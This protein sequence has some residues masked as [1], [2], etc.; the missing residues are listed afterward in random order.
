MTL[1][2][3]RMN[4]VEEQRCFLLHRLAEVV[5]EIGEGLQI[6]RTALNVAEEEPLLGEIRDQGIGSRVRE[7][8]F[9]L[10]IQHSGVLQL[11]LRRNRQQFLVRDT[12]PQEERKA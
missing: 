12:A 6:R 9:H 10:L 8:A 3:S 1:L 5:I 7:H 4:A 2:S 11:P